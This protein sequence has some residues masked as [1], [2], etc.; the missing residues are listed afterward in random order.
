MSYDVE[1]IYGGLEGCNFPHMCIARSCKIASHWRN[2]AGYMM[3]S[4]LYLSPTNSNILFPLLSCQRSLVD[5]E[6]LIE[7]S[8]ANISINK[9]HRS[10]INLFSKDKKECKKSSITS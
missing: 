6:S 7:L 5:T 2:R 8:G 10:R 3:L 9:A 1:H 4:T